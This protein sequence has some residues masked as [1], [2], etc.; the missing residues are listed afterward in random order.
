MAEA[1]WGRR[2]NGV[3]SRVI[4]GRGW[5]RQ[6]ATFTTENYRSSY[7]RFTRAFFIHR[8][9][10]ELYLFAGCPLW[11][12]KVNRSKYQFTPHVVGVY[13]LT[14]RSDMYNTFLWWSSS[15]L[16]GK[17]QENTRNSLYSRR[18]SDR[19]FLAHIYRTFLFPSYQV[20]HE[21]NIAVIS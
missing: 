3:G 21:Q 2:E 11:I 4:L 8:L 18:A 19:Q 16:C 5:T 14:K 6:S 13:Q 12:Q 20:P 9:Y 10:N 1:F 15:K 17:V 7:V